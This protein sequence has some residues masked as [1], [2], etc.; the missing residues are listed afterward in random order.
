VSAGANLTQPLPAH[1]KEVLNRIVTPYKAD[2]FES[3]L[4]KFN[5][6]SRYPDLVYNMRNGFP[7]GDM[8]PLTR[9]YT[10]PNHKSALDNPQ[11]IRDYLADEVALSRMSGPFTAAQVEYELGGFFVSCPMGLVEKA[12]EPGK[13]RIIRDL[14]YHNKEDGYSV[15][16]HLNADD[17]PTEWG[18]AAQVAEIVSTFTPFQQAS[19]FSRRSHAPL[20]CITSASLAWLSCLGHRHALLRTLL[21][22]FAYLI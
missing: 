7:I 10:P 3:F 8:P 22:P 20:S 21:R 11:V 15:N 16:E 17:F 2:A 6:T 13:Y 19:S 12:G 5:L 14:S 4:D 18:T 1:V 9:T